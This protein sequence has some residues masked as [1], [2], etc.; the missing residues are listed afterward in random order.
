M[1]PLWHISSHYLEVGS[2]SGCSLKMSKV[3]W[4]E[5]NCCYISCSY[6]TDWISSLQ[7]GKAA[8]RTCLT[9]HQ[10]R[11]YVIGGDTVGACARRCNDRPSYIG[12]VF[13]CRAAFLCHSFFR[14]WVMWARCVAFSNQHREILKRV[15]PEVLIS[16][17]FNVY[18]VVK[19]KNLCW[20]TFCHI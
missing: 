3:T 19:K 2:F 4:H 12:G 18:R 16:G 14:S 7:S 15:Q 5:T 17:I 9:I 10:M 6:D 11:R 20:D 8:T 13:I 1:T